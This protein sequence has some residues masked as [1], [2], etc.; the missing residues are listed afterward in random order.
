MILASRLILSIACTSCQE[1]AADEEIGEAAAFPLRILGR[2]LQV[3]F[4]FLG[5]RFSTTARRSHCRAT[6]ALFLGV[7]LEAEYC[8]SVKVWL[9]PQFFSALQC[10]ESEGAR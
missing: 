9:R 10:A 1:D 7:P 6:A 2:V 4:D 5:L 8:I 3:S